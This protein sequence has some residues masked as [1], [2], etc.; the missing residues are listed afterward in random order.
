MSKQ[1]RLPTGMPLHS[2]ERVFKQELDRYSN[3]LILEVKSVLNRKFEESI[4]NAVVEIFPDE[5]GDG[6]LSMGIHLEGSVITY[7]PLVEEARDMPLIDVQAY[8]GEMDLVDKI[9]DWTKQWCAECWWKAG[10]WDWAVPTS[11]QGH[12]GFGNGDAI[13]LT[14]KV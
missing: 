11:L 9:V 8:E 1:K 14:S 12:S 7:I 5:F 3:Q 10:G 4:S 6:F 13:Q 2:I